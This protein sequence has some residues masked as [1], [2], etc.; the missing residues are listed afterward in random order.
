MVLSYDNVAD[1]LTKLLSQHKHDSYAKSIAR[2]NYAQVNRY[3]S[4]DKNERFSQNIT[5]NDEDLKDV[6]CPHDDALVIVADI[7]DFDVK[8]VLVDTGSAA[9]VMSW[10]VFLGL[11]I[12]PSKIK[13]VTTLLHGFGGA[14]VIPEGTIE[15]PVTLGTYPASVVRMTNFLLV[16]APKAYNA[17][18]GCP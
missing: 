1:L 4:V 13:P 3:T 12:S 7:A 5:F 17:I 18:Y 8:R 11:R 16:K 15:L 2:N 14:T 6:T 9:D 10:R